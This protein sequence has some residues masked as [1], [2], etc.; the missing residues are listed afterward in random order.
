MQFMVYNPC[1]CAAVG[2]ITSLFSSC[3]ASLCANFFKFLFSQFLSLL[4]RCLAMASSGDF[5]LCS[6]CGVPHEEPTGKR[7]CKRA[8]PDDLVPQSQAS[9]PTPGAGRVAGAE[10]TS[11]MQDSLTTLITV[12]SSLAT[13]LDA[14]RLDQLQGGIQ[15]I[16]A[17][18]EPTMPT[19]ATGA[20]PKRPQLSQPCAWEALS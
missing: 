18:V 9:V 6:R 3:N 19:A 4:L 12:V 5:K 14:Q 2:V 13:R 16:Q 8:L 17:I 15:P 1:A 11:I 7:K 10:G 20:I